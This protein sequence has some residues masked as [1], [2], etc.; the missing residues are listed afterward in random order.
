MRKE[1]GGQN[2]N[3]RAYI[4][5]KIQIHWTVISLRSEWPQG[6][7]SFWQLILVALIKSL[8]KLPSFLTL[9]AD[10]PLI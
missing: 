2:L 9:T 4:Y 8:T 6:G 1:N 3:K 5:S 7:I 10:F